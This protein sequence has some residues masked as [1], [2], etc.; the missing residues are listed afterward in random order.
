MLP[1]AQRKERAPKEK[2]SVREF[3]FFPPY[4]CGNITDQSVII[5]AV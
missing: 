3:I 2:G 5:A 1:A 4:V